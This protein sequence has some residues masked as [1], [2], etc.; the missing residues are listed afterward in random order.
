M[1]KVLPIGNDSFLTLRENDWYYIDKTLMIKDFIEYQDTVALITRPRRFGKTLNMTMLRE[2]FDITKESE[3]IFEGLAIM[4]TDYAV[5]I[6]T[7]PVI[8][9]SFKDCTGKTS[10]EL[11]YNLSEEL[12]K[13]YRRYNTIFGETV[14]RNDLFYIKYNKLLNDMVQESTTWMS[15]G[16]AINHL[17]TAVT[18]FF[19]KEP[20]LLVDEYDQPIL[21][22]Y[23]NGYHDELKDFFSTFYGSALKGNEYLGQALLTGIQRV[24]KESI[25]SK[26]NNVVVYSM[27]RKEYSS[28]FGLMEEEAKEL[29]DIYG[30][31]F[32]D[33]VK[34]KYDGYRIGGHEVYNPWSI[35][36]YAK[37]G[38]LD[39][40]W[41]NTSTNYLVKEA[42]ETADDFFKKDFELLIQHGQTEVSANLKLSFIELQSNEAL[43][44]L[45]VNSGYVTVAERADEFF[46]TVQIPK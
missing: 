24:A 34:Q 26:L 16:N 3:A 36:N 40:Y 37:S 12:F 35:L 45:L 14:N 42:L 7:R 27:L 41:I 39:N 13:E 31:A 20:I 10:E 25:F 38:I 32:D 22:S 30:L 4:S 17:L 9:F 28:Y 5:Q 6:N 1:K 11:K 44:G 29:L 33:R 15:L 23:Q 46:M 21:S 43:W 2:F 8:Y 19:E 18:T